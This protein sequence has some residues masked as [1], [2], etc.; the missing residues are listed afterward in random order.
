M[1]SAEAVVARHRDVPHHGDA[2]QGLDVGVVWLGFERVPEEDQR[3][4]GDRSRPPGTILTARAP[5][6]LGPE[7]KATRP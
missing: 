5:G 1:K 2:E 3:V 6:Q 4:N 7:P